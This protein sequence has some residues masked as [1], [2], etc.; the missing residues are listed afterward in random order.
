MREEI[1]RQ[2]KQI[3]ELRQKNQTIVQEM[4]VVKIENVRQAKNINS[5]NER[6]SKI[7][8]GNRENQKKLE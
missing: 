6:I 8:E 3:Q 7:H 2:K 5:L 1:I 4:R